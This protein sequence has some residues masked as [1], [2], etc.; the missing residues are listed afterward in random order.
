METIDG[1]N[2]LTIQEVAEKLGMSLS[3]ARLNVRK[4]GMPAYRVPGRGQPYIYR[5]SDLWRIQKPEPVHRVERRNRD[6][7]RRRRRGEQ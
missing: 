5:E 7:E 3:A 6:I 4:F 1:E 2:Y